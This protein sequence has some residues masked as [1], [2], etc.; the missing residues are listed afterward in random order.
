MDGMLFDPGESREAPKVTGGQPRLRLAQR[1][2]VEM[3]WCSLD[4]LL[5]PGPS[6]TGDLG[7]DPQ[8]GPERL[9]Q[10]NQSGGRERRAGRHGP[11][12]PDLALDPGHLGRRGK[13]P[14]PGE[15]VR[16][17]Y[18]LSMVVRRG[19]GQPRHALTV[20]LARREPVGRLADPTGRHAD[21]RKP[22]DSQACRPGRDARAGP[23]GQG[24]VPSQDAV[25]GLP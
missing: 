8:L 7:R 1:D 4:E 20:S 3:R 2:Q 13:Q 23:C 11:P 6:G 12:N 25:A 14:T 21:G 24:V 10:G 16:S 9:A 17:P 18:R 15:A 22:G 5:D 19:H